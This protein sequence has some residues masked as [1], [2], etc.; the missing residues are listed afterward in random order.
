VPLVTTLA[1]G[2]AGQQEA[3]V[4]ALGLEVVSHQTVVGP[5][6]RFSVT[7]LVAN[8]T[9]QSFSTFSLQFLP[10]D[11][12]KPLNHL[13]QQPE[14]PPKSTIAVTTDLVMEGSFAT[15][16]LVVATLQ[17]GNGEGPPLVRFASTDPLALEHESGALEEKFRLLAA[18]GLVTLL[19]GMISS[20]LTLKLKT[21]AD[22]AAR[23]SE[24]ERNRREAEARITS[25][26]IALLS[27]NNIAIQR[28]DPIVR[29]WQKIISGEGVYLAL[30]RISSR[31]GD[32][33]LPQRLSELY[34]DFADYQSRIE[35]SPKLIDS[36]LQQKIQSRISS[37][38]QVL[39]VDH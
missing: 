4:N 22:D 3:T 18:G 36:T 25:D 38:L 19:T 23:A 9:D 14:I 20:V 34:I 13:A 6:G 1:T 35:L 26:L 12:F 37:L 2:L 31:K 28:K 17:Q 30:H 27:A 32:L 15:S 8:H 39:T 33:N 24:L 16:L 11:V 21:R 7:V 29:D 10:R 5:E